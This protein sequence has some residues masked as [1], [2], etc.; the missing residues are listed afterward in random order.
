[1]PPEPPERWSVRAASF[2][3][4]PPQLSPRSFCR[5]TH[6]RVHISDKSL[7]NSTKRKHTTSSTRKERKKSE[8]FCE[9]FAQIF[10]RI[11]NSSYIC[12]RF[13]RSTTN[14]CGSSVWLE[15]RPVTPEVE[16]SSPF[17]TAKP[18][19]FSPGLC[20]F[21]PGSPPSYIMI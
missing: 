3:G 16:G 9:N 12:I 7:K 21:Y 13:Q 1:M 5:K 10:C 20:R 8:D 2:Y 17:R 18:W 15:R 6:P 19:R 4:T 11:K 14:W